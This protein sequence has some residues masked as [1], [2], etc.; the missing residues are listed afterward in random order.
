MAKLPPVDP[1]SSP[2]VAATFK[3]IEASR[4][5]VSNLMRCLIHSP[6]GTQ[7][8][9]TYG[10]FMRFRTDLK[11]RQRELVICATVRGVS[12]GWVHHG[13][14]LRQLG[15]SEAQMAE[16]ENGKVPQGL[17]ADEQALCA[18]IFEFTACRGL[19]DAV[20]TEVRRHFSDKQ[21]VDASLLSA[22][23]MGGGALIT[24]FAPELDPPASMQAERDWQTR[25]P[26]R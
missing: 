14:L 8:H 11:E 9:V 17:P 2:E 21:I 4:G 5:Y 18:Y 19:S 12:Y 22:Y 20:L 16:L 1:T 10:H 15:L 3:Q 25:R 23:F 24:A 26:H 7:A 13:Q 6:E